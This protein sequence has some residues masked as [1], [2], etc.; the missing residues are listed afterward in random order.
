MFKLWRTIYITSFLLPAFLPSPFFFS[1]C[2][3]IEHDPS[4][5]TVSM[6]AGVIYAC[7]SKIILNILLLLLTKDTQQE[8]TI[9]TILVLVSFYVVGHFLCFFLLFLV[10]SYIYSLCIQTILF[11]LCIQ[12]TKQ[13]RFDVTSLTYLIC[14]FSIVS[15]NSWPLLYFMSHSV[16]WNRAVTLEISGIFG[17]ICRDSWTVNLFDGLILLFPWIIWL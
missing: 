12:S 4:C 7:P 14:R 13:L 3:C 15:I 11:H 1:R 8:K 10:N 2:W 9:E 17:Q 5:C 16:H 6:V